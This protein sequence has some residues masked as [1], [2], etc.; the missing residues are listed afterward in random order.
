MNNK[1]SIAIITKNEELNIG[2]CLNSVSWAD[3]IIVVDSGST[4]KTIDI[5]TEHNCKIILTDWLGFAKTKQLAVDNCR[6]DWVLVLDADEVITEPLK[7]K[8]ETILN[9]PE[10]SGY[11]IKRSSFYL[12][13]MI[14]HCGW[15]KDYTLR[16]FDKNKGRFNEKLV[17]ESVKIENGNIGVIEEVM[18]HY[19]YQNITHHVNKI[20][21]YTTLS[22]ENMFLNSKSY[23]LIGGLFRAFWG[24]FKMYILKLGF[25]DGIEGFILSINSSY[26]I[27]L[28][29][30]KLWEK[31]RT[32]K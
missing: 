24:F 12:G 5:C 25:M 1:L 26:Y 30:S 2:R 13:K 29:Y 28:K 16:L 14:K 15:D 18:F 11:K 20:N 27:F 8:I 7:F 6:N 9:N 23:T 31:R 19:T 4:D 21:Q 3:E 32:I 22:A 17:H 10:V